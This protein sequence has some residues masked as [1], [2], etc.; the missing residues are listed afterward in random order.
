MGTCCMLSASCLSCLTAVAWSSR[1][2]DS[3]CRHWTTTT[4]L[5]NTIPRTSL[6]SSTEPSP[7]YS[8]L[9]SLNTTVNTKIQHLCSMK[10]SFCLHCFSAVCVQ[11]T[12]SVFAV[13]VECVSHWSHH[14]SHHVTPFKVEC[15]GQQ[16]E[17][18]SLF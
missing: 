1:R 14:Q 8:H 10:N 6:L 5:W 17:Q 9:P 16:K 18:G 15:I 13:Y 3:V 11:T 7:R 12:F 2:G 4:R